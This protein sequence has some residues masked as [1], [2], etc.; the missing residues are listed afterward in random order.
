MM[1]PLGRVLWR[2]HFYGGLIFIPFMILLAITGAI[3]LVVDEYEGLAYASLVQSSAIGPDERIVPL[4][5]QMRL[6]RARYPAYQ[7]NLLIV[8]PGR[9][10]EFVLGRSIAAR[11]NADDK[12]TSAGSGWAL[13]ATESPGRISV[14]VDPVSGGILGVLN[15]DTRFMHLIKKL[16]SELLLGR[17]GT[18][19]VEL[20]ANWGIVLVLMGGILWW[21]RLGPTRSG[22]LWPRWR[23]GGSSRTYWRNLHAVVGIYLLLPL[24]FLLFSGLPWTDVWG[25]LFK[26]FKQAIGQAAPASFFDRSVRSVDRGDGQPIDLDRLMGIIQSEGVDGYLKIRLPLNDRGAFNVLRESDDPSQRV[27]LQIDQYSGRVLHRVRWQDNPWLERLVAVAIKIHRG[28]YFGR[29]NQMLGLVTALLL[30]VVSISGLITWLK[31]RPRGCLAP[32]PRP[33]SWQAPHWL[34]LCITIAAVSLPLLG[35]SL[36]AVFVIN[37]SMDWLRNRRQWRQREM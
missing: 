7:P 9:N 31:R 22:V 34:L 11:Q 26:H 33:A 12:D 18:K 1:D 32:P 30:I 13:R 37:H 28:E 8:R 3:Y 27:V 21:K 14:F 23:K 24:L 29:T 20:A 16:H 35:L 4:Q 17:F 10:N 15:D 2:W 36:L 5:S 25:G 19:F 6:V